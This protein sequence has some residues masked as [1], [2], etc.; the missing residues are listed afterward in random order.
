MQMALFSVSVQGKLN[1]YNPYD[2]GVDSS[3]CLRQKMSDAPNS[4]EPTG[5]ANRAESES[6]L[7]DHSPLWK[8]V[9]K[10]EKMGKGGRNTSFQ[11]NFC[12][13]IYKGSYSRVKS[14]LL[15]I[16]GG[17]IAS[18]SKVTNAT[19]SEMHKEVEKA[20][21]RVKQSLPRQIPLPTTSSGKTIGF[22]IGSTYH[23]L[24]LPSL[25][26]KKRKGMS[27]PIEKALNIGVKEQ[28]D[29]EIARMF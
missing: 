9:T 13:Q 18:C 16:K 28:L 3:K 12:Q 4:F 23:G 5:N 19:L 7:N 2:D 1:M 8:Y 11:F 21:F 6:A 29:S 27:G 24:D 22:S 17:G 26:P 25:G 10:L 15:K 20:E 14:H